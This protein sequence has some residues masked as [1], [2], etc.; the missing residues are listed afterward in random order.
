MDN[1]QSYVNI[2]ICIYK[3]KL[4]KYLKLSNVK[5]FELYIILFLAFCPSCHNFIS[6]S[7]KIYSFKKGI[8]QTENAMVNFQHLNQS[9]NLS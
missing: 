2:N 4:Y 7:M 5:T 3:Y 8:D 1:S 9:H 6:K